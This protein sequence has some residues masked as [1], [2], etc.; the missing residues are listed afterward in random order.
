MGYHYLLFRSSVMGEY[1]SKMVEYSGKEYSGIWIMMP[2]K[3]KM[4]VT[5]I[6]YP[7]VSLFADIGGYFGLMLGISINQLAD[8]IIDVVINSW[9]Y[10]TKSN[11]VE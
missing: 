9:I 7:A 2:Q 3:I 6:D 8:Y 10:F 11:I 4:T 1:N 5:S